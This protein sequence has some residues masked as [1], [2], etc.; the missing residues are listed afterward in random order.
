MPEGS[1]LCAMLMWQQIRYQNRLFWRTPVAAFFTLVF[2]LIFLLL[3]SV[4]F[5][6]GGHQI[7]GRGVYSVATVLHAGVGG[8]PAAS[9]T[10]TNIGVGTAI[11][12]DEESSSGFAAPRCP[13]RPTSQ[14]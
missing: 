11:A 1:Y 6:N 10:D 13:P 2:P 4:L 12:R 8:I 14:A 5:G 7:T 9:A 3:F